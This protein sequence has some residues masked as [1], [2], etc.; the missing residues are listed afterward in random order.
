MFPRLRAALG[1]VA[2]GVAGGGSA[3]AAVLL[4]GTAS[5]ATTVQCQV[6]YSVGSDWTLGYSYGGNQRLQ[7]G[8][9]G[10]WSQSGQAVTVANATYNGSVA[11]GASTSIGAN[12][13]YSGGN[14]APTVLRCT[15]RATGSWTAPA[16]SSSRTG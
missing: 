11:A 10:T 8:W 9:N 1:A 12:F 3:T 7:N 2:T 13:T 16:R 4:P 15:S 6:T 14:T 5:A